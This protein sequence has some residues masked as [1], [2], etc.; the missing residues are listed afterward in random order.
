MIRLS[1]GASPAAIIGE[2]RPERLANAIDRAAG[3]QRMRNDLV[4]IKAQLFGN[5]A[6]PA[7]FVERYGV[8]PS[9]ASAL[10]AELGAKK[11]KLGQYKL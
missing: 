7:W 10:L 2:P 1:R 5:G 4:R 6:K 11:T 3:V 8:W 9:D